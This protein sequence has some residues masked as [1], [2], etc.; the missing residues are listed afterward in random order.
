MFRKKKIIQFSMNYT[1]YNNH[2]STILIFVL[3]T[4]CHFHQCLLGIFRDKNQ[5]EPRAVFGKIH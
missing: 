2:K 1:Q 3:F 4:F 5:I